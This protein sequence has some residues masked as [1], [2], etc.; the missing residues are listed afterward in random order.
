VRALSTQRD[1]C[2]Q[3]LIL[4]AFWDKNEAYDDNKVINDVG[5]AYIAMKNTAACMSYQTLK[6]LYIKDLQWLLT[7]YSNVTFPQLRDVT[8]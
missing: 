5:S 3:N 1:R 6:F 7:Q 2:I 4:M 8:F